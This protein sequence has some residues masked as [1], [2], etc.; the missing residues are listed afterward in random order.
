MNCSYHSSLEA[1][2][3]CEKCKNPICADCAI[4]VEEKTVCR[5]CVQHNL[6]SH[7]PTELKKPF[8]ERLLFFICSLIP[9]A[10]H[11]KMGLFRRGVQ[12]M[13][14]AFG[15]I[16]LARYINLA[17]LMPVILIPTWFFSFF[18]SHNLKRQFW[19][20]QAL[21][22]EDIFDQS[23]L[24]HSPLLKNR[25]VIGILII[26]LGILG[27]AQVVEPYTV[28]WLGKDYFMIKDSMIPVLLI[29]S[30]IYLVIKAKQVPKT[31][32]APD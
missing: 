27:L 25:R 8:L 29:A 32:Q 5:H 6:F 28:V 31:S 17:F 20:G 15:V 12:L 18:E 14:I 23:L 24:K 26:V 9:G 21:R 2:T 19:Q 30:G 7:P 1:Q 4:K 16:S 3:I 11:M 10:A 13:V 22:D